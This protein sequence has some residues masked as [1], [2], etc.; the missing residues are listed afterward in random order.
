MSCGLAVGHINFMPILSY[1]KSV[2]DDVEFLRMNPYIK[3][4][5]K[6]SGWIYET[7]K[8]TIEEV[9]C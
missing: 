3:K 9:E 2:T 7:T 1:K 8:G 6:I 5:V 4:G